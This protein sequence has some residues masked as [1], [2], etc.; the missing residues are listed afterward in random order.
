MDE[1]VHPKKREKN[2]T[3]TRGRA[4]SDRFSRLPKSPS[5]GYRSHI[6]TLN[7]MKTEE[8]DFFFIT[9]IG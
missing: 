7:E 9:F 5:R 6:T 8:K 4:L 3:P 1:S 2:S